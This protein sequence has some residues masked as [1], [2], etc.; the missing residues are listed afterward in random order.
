MRADYIGRAPGRG[1]EGMGKFR[2][3]AQGVITVTHTQP[4][5]GRLTSTASCHAGRRR[6]LRLRNRLIASPRDAVIP[7]QLMPG[8][9]LQWPVA[10][11]A[12]AET[13]VR[14]PAESQAFGGLGQPRSRQGVDSES[15]D[16]AQPTGPN[17]LTFKLCS[18]LE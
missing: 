2:G 12:A 1:P 15:A 7:W 14:G 6:Q 16:S 18:W 3:I 5:A 13:G 9:T 10:A 17:R 4:E 11:A 8:S